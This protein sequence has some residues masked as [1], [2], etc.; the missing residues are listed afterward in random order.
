MCGRAHLSSDVEKLTRVFSIP[1][2]H[3]APNV[4]ASWNVAPTDPLPVVRYNGRTGER[5]L[6]VLRWGLVPFWARDIKVGFANINARAE[7]IDTRP[8]FRE[9]FTRRRCLVPIDSYYEWAKTAAGKQPYA[10][11]LTGRGIMALA[12]LWETWRSP[13]DELVR[14]FAIV[15]TVPNALCGEIHNR[16]PVILPPAAWPL[17]LGAKIGANRHRIS[18]ESGR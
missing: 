12:G 16:M 14:S 1:P 13:A 11:A 15:T 3:P 2:S 4:A 17:W 9:A 5:S 18:V 10:F 8:A 6:D 7:G